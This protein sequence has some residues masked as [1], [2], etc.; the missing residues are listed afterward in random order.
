MGNQRDVRTAHEQKGEK[1]KKKTADLS[2]TKDVHTSV[3]TLFFAAPL[4]SDQ[5]AKHSQTN[6]RSS[7]SKRDN[8]NNNKHKVGSLH[9]ANYHRSDGN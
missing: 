5:R 9:T 1:R 6:C 3:D 4:S 2:N 7:S 8:R